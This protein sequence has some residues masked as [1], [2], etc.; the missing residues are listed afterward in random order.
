[1]I[2]YV[3]RDDGACHRLVLCLFY[4]GLK[5][6]ERKVMR[7]RSEILLGWKFAGQRLI[8]RD[9]GA[10]A[11][12]GKRES[13]AIIRAGGKTLKLFCCK[14]SSRIGHICL[15]SIFTLVS[16]ACG[17]AYL[18]WVNY[19]LTIIRYKALVQQND[20]PCQDC[21]FV[22]CSFAANRTLQGARGFDS[23]WC[24]FVGARYLKFEALNFS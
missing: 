18:S 24:D 23:C 22:L 16:P 21:R 11:V 20:S 5:M 19:P 10:V 17:E 15:F 1:M 12:G 7:F 6:S 14:I 3:E 4:S 8:R 2:L 13:V 9:S